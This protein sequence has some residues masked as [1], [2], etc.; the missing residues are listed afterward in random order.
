MSVS[1]RIGVAALALATTAAAPAA[2]WSGA[3]RVVERQQIVTPTLGIGP[4]GAFVAW[5]AT[6][7]NVAGGPVMVSAVGPTP[8]APVDI[9]GGATAVGPLTVRTAGAPLVVWT[10]VP[11]GAAT[12]SA[13]RIALNGVTG[14]GPQV[15]PGSD[16]LLLVGAAGGADGTVALVGR[17]TAAGPARLGVLVRRPDGSWATTYT[18]PAGNGDPAVDVGAGGVVAVMA[19][20]ATYVR[21]ADGGWSAGPRLAVRQ[22][23]TARDV[24]VAADGDVRA[25]WQVSRPYGLSTLW[26]AGRAPDGTITP[27]SPM[28]GPV[29]AAALSPVGGGVGL[30]WGTPAGTPRFTASLPGGGWSPIA[31]L[32][33]PSPGCAAAGPMSLAGLPDGGAVVIWP[34]AGAVWTAHRAPDGRWDPAVPLNA[35]VRSATW[36]G[37]VA[38]EAGGATV[39]WAHQGRTDAAGGFSEVLDAASTDAAGM[40]VAAP[41]VR[42]GTPPLRGV[43]AV[44]APRGV[45]RVAV[46][47]GT[48][49]GA[50]VSVGTSAYPADAV[51]SPRSVRGTGVRRTVV[52]VPAAVRGRAVWVSA[53]AAGRVSCVR[54]VRV[55]V[56]R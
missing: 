43:S 23:V 2:A 26:T 49:R 29:W 7:P 16:G 11:A 8:T 10:E 39:A 20:D 42:M 3:V 24:A 1:G 9:S 13:V 12:A 19:G 6:R 38:D 56:R 18:V 28:A 35:S 50:T 45:L 17:S 21:T 48:A 54:Q 51:V 40:A 27:P 30:V 41:W 46:R 33:A 55:R 22:S 32:G 34:E 53:Q 31:T 25:A 47:F 52:Q 44:A 36:L 5:T 4:A 14:T 37:L 15:V